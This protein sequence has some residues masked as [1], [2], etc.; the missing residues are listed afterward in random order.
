MVCMR[1]EPCPAPTF[2]ILRSAVCLSVQCW[3]QLPRAGKHSRSWTRSPNLCPC[4]NVLCSLCR[5]GWWGTGGRGGRAASVGCFGELG[6]HGGSGV[7][8]PLCQASPQPHHHSYFCAEGRFSS[9]MCAGVKSGVMTAR[10]EL[11]GLP[12]S[13]CG[14]MGHPS[15]MGQHWGS[16]QRGCWQGWPRDLLGPSCVG[17]GRGV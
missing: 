6:G 17:K 14:G 15:A 16:V 11:E 13:P 8:R 12:A 10:E 9:K 7:T 3:E 5:A 2:V 1:A 4:P